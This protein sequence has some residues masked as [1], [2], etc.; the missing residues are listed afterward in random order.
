[1]HFHCWGEGCVLCDPLMGMCYGLNVFPSNSYVEALTVIVTQFGDRAF[2]GYWFSRISDFVRR[3]NSAS[4]DDRA[5]TR[6][7]S[8]SLPTPSFLLAQLCME[9]KPFQDTERRQLSTSREESSHQKLN[10]LAPWSWTSHL[11][12][13]E[14]INYC[15][16]FLLVLSCGCPSKLTHCPLQSIFVSNFSRWHFLFSLLGIFMML[17]YCL[18][19]YSF[20]CVGSGILPC[21]S[22]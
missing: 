2:M 22:Q 19:A 11:Q 7:L 14:K 4:A 13:C 21:P 16:Y 12:N 9:E 17:Y 20:S 15:C 1:M 5:C 8:P 3:D 10:W 6:D 18:F